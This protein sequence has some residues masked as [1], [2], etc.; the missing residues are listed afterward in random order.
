MDE[1]EANATDPTKLFED[2]LKIADD[3]ILFG[4]TSATKN[5]YEKYNIML[6]LD[7][8]SKPNTRY[9]FMAKAVDDL[10]VPAKQVS[11]TARYCNDCT[12]PPPDNPD[13]GFSGGAI[14]GIIV[15]AVVLAALVGFLIFGGLVFTGVVEKP[16]IKMPK[17]GKN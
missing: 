17:M 16:N 10:D 7:V 11:N 6:K 13:D 1:M 12:P 5:A 14:F 15:G 3:D 9:I 4:D 8:F 2:A